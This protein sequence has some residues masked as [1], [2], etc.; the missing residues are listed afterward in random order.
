MVLRVAVFDRND[1]GAD[2]NVEYGN[3]IVPQEW[4]YEIYVYKCLRCDTTEVD[5]FD[6]W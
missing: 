5:V 6:V 2:T 3:V 1:L 4:Q